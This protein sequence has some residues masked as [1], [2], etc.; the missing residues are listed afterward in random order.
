MKYLTGAIGPGT[1]ELADRGVVGMMAQPMS[2]YAPESIRRYPWYACDNA[3]FSQGKKFEVFP[4]LDWLDTMPRENCLFATAPDVMCDAEA[5]WRRS[6]PVLP[7]IRDHGFKAALV[8]QN[9][10]T[11]DAVEWDEIDCV[12]IGGDDSWKYAPAVYTIVQ[13]ARLRG[14][15]THMGR[16]NSEARLR[17]AATIGCE[18]ADGTFLKFAPDHNIGRMLKWFANMQASPNLPLHAASPV[19]ETCQSM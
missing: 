2:A 3:C 12:F 18:S 5:T 6:K 15:W 16:V 19:E 1:H 13:E 14:K 17:Y 4:Y 10:L 8:A 7:L 9:G 11:A